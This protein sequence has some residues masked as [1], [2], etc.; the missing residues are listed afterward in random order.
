MPRAD[1]LFGGG[2]FDADDLDD[3]NVLQRDM[4]ADGGLRPVT[5]EQVLAVRRRAALAVQAVFRE[6]G[7]PAITGEEVEAAVTAH[8][9]L[10]VPARDVVADLEAAERFLVEG[11][12]GVGIIR[13]L[14]AHGFQD[15]AEKI[16]AIQKLRVSGD[17]LQTS[18]M[19]TGDGK[20]LSAINDPNDYQGPGTGYQLTPERYAEIEDIPQALDPHRIGVAEATEARLI[21]L[22]DAAPGQ[23]PREVVIALGPAFGSRL[24]ETIL[25][26]PHTLVLEALAAGIREE[27]LTARV[28]KI[29]S[30]SDCGFIGHAGAQLSGSGIAIG[31]QSKG[32][33]VIHRQDLE[34]LNTLELFPQAPNL[35]LESYRAI[36]RNAAKYAKRE[37]VLPVP[38]Q[39]DNMARLKHIV[40]TTILHLVET[41]QV[42]PQKPAQE[43]AYAG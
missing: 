11:R 3:Y 15:I 37:P 18:A 13:A 32:T 27:G 21:E 36:G 4:L 38:V 9:S 7:L 40:K 43:I 10:D 23:D 25:G 2:N 30:T 31:I 1:N 41:G 8:S 34:P 16:L 42:V 14:A 22:G 12:N 28:V 20:L 17:Y 35:T 39:I 6:L 29:Y 26:L 24:C 33:T 19:V 5:E